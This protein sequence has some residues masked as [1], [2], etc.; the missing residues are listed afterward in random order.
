MGKLVALFCFIAMRGLFQRFVI[1]SN[2]GS[3]HELYHW[4][5]DASLSF[6]MTI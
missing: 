4:K 6:S 3:I 2:E 1:L 5:I